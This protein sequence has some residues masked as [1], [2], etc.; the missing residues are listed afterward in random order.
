MRT[1]W[2]ERVCLEPVPIPQFYTPSALGDRAVALAH[3]L[4]LDTLGLGGGVMRGRFGN[5]PLPSLAGEAARSE[6]NRSREPVG[7][8]HPTGNRGHS[9]TLLMSRGFLAPAGAMVNSKGLPAPG[10]RSH[11]GPR[12]W[13]PLAIFRCPFGA[14]QTQ[15][16]I[17]SDASGWYPVQARLTGVAARI[18]HSTARYRPAGRRPWRRRISSGLSAACAGPLTGFAPGPRGRRGGRRE[19]AGGDAGG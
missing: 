14:E 7:F 2:F 16:N 4:A 13:K 18:T 8:T 3:R 10:P 5:R 9:L 15:R 1:A 11:S 6:P 17:K 12:G 19:G